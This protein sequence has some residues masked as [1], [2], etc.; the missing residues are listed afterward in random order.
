[1]EHFQVIE[2]PIV[3]RCLEAIVAVCAL[4]P[5][6]GKTALIDCLVEVIDKALNPPMLMGGNF[7]VGTN[8]DQTATGE[9]TPQG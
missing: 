1:M 2:E 5:S 6:T 4:P 9:E 7:G 3:N 8:N